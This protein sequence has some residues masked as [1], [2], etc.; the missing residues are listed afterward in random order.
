MNRKRLALA[1]AAGL[2]AGAWWLAPSGR[3]TDTTPSAGADHG[4]VRP[5]GPTG[6]AAMHTP[7]GPGGDSGPDTI[8]PGQPPRPPEPNRL[9]MDF[10]PEQR[11]EFA[12]RGHGPGG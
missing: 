2:A 7:Q 6:P 1:V 4:L 3:R 11:V 10:T 12:R 9:F 5:R 8:R